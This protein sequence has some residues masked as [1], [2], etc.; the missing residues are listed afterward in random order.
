MED[1]RRILVGS[2]MSKYCPRAL[3]YGIAAARS[4]WEETAHRVAWAAVKKLYEKI[5][6]HWVKKAE[7]SEGG[8]AVKRS[9]GLK[10]PQRTSF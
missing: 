6:D 3:R 10:P 8:K 4:S 2:R 5:G 9:P 1:I 7:G